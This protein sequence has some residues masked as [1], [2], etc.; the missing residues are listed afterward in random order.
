MPANGSVRKV[1]MDFDDLANGNSRLDILKRLKERDPGFKVTLFAI[2]AR[3][4]DSLLAEY[5]AEKSWIQLAIHGFR[6]SRHEALGWLQDEAEDKLARAMAIYPFAPVF[7]AP[8]WQ[9]TD[10]VYAACLVR[11]LAVADHLSNVA[12]IPKEMPVYIYNMRLRDDPYLRI[13]GHI[14][15]WTHT[16]T[17]GL[18]EAYEKWSSPEVGSEYLFVTDAISPWQGV[19]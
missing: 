11:G 2:P 12:I 19:G 15:D 10:E 9:M 1:I 14:Q 8:N 4:S 6:H 5:D 3:C 7:K 13:H 17:D 16:G 18:E